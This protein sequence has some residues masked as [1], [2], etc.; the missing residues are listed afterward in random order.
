MEY[1]EIMYGDDA[2]VHL[3]TRDRALAPYIEKFGRV[4]AKRNPDIF[5]VLVSCIIGQ[6]L[7]GKAA[8]TIESRVLAVCGG[9]TPA[10]ILAADA[11]KMRAAGLSAMKWNAI[12]NAARRVEAKEVDLNDM[13]HLSDEEYVLKLMEFK[14]VGR[15]TAEMIAIFAEGRLDV[16][17]FG[18][19]A[20][21]KAVMKVHGYQSYSKERYERLKKA[22][23]P[24]G[25]VASLY[26]YAINESE[27]AAATP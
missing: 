4:S 9:F 14:G 1:T 25:T 10:K 8:T 21:Q 26:Y 7:S 13:H 6:Q 5:A 19:L 2:M 24:Y 3:M 22:Y 11:E 16:F 27:G 17:S 20:I 18:D 12:Q 15:W 23:S